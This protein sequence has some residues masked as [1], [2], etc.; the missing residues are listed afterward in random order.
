MTLRAA[1]LPEYDLYTHEKLNKL[2][3][4]QKAQKEESAKSHEVL[5]SDMC[6]MKSM[7][8]SV[9]ANQAILMNHLI[10]QT[11]PG[12]V[13]PPVPPLH[14]HQNEH[15]QS[16][17]FNHPHING[18]A[19]EVE[20]VRPEINVDFGVGPAVARGGMQ[21]VSP[22]TSPE[23]PRHQEKGKKR[24]GSSGDGRH[25][26]AGKR[27]KSNGVSDVFKEMNRGQQMQA[28]P[29]G[30]EGYSKMKIFEFV[31]AVASKRL[32]GIINPSDSNPLRL[33]AKETSKINVKL[34]RMLNFLTDNCETEEELKIWTGK[35]N[36]LSANADTA[37]REALDARI[38]LV[39]KALSRR[40]EEWLDSVGCLKKMDT[41]G[42]LRSRIETFKTELNK[43]KLQCKW[44]REKIAQIRT[45][46]RMNATEALAAAAAVE[47]GAE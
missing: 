4:Q 29:S 39:A 28:A 11:N 31:T 32:Q 8:A 21:T 27:R 19:P 33:E 35:Y 24:A 3:S 36:V 1:K 10:N 26:P 44:D 20:V 13:V 17:E 41:C 43:K 6:S 45:R 38:A 2:L 23:Q 18:A 14:Q 15:N 25:I 37:A 5:V 47:G 9:L 40:A 7:L 16:L 12:N 30:L 34:W 22:T 42:T 46:K